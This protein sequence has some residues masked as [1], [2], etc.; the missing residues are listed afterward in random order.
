[1]GVR[2]LPNWISQ[3]FTLIQNLILEAELN[4]EKIL[5][6][7]SQSLSQSPPYPAPIQVNHGE[8]GGGPA[9]QMECLS[10]SF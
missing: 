4:P 9:G 1:M 3:D 6:P 7:G 8:G 5:F 2:I 10:F